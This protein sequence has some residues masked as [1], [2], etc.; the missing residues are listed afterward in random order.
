LANDA[1]SNFATAVLGVTSGPGL[2]LNPDGSFQYVPA[3]PGQFQFTYVAFDGVNSNS[4]T[5]SINVVAMPNP[6]VVTT[7]ADSGPGSLRAAMTYANATPGAQTITFAI[8]GV[9]PAAPA[10]INLQTGLPII[11]D[12]VTIDATT[13][14]GYD[15]RPVVELT[16]NGGGGVAVGFETGFDVNSVTIRGF[17]LTRFLSAGIRLLQA[18]TA[19]PGT[20]HVVTGN[21]LGTDRNSASLKGNSTGIIVRRDGA[22]VTGNVI[23]GNTGPGVL[24]HIDADGVQIVN[25]TIGLANDNVV[26]RPNAAGIRMLDSVDNTIIDG[27]IIAGNNG[28]GIDIQDSLAGDVTGTMIIAN[29]IGLNQLGDSVPNSL[30]GIQINNAPGTQIGIAGNGNVIS[31]HANATFLSG[32]PGIR[33]LGSPAVVPTIRANRIGTD[34]TGQ[35]ARPNRFE[36]IILYGRAEVGGLRSAN[37]GNLIS[38]NGNIGTGG[39][40]GILIGAGAEGSIVRGNTIGLTAGGA[41]LGNAYS[42]ITVSGDVTSI[43]IGGD[44]ND[45]INTISGNPAAGITVYSVDGDNPPGS[46]PRPREIQIQGNSIYGNGGLGIDLDNDGVSVN[47]TGDTDPLVG[48]AANDLQNYPALTSAVNNGATTQV[49]VDLSTLV[50]G[51]TYRVRFFAS[52]ACDTVGHGEGQT[53][54]GLA[55]IVQPG[56]SANLP[57]V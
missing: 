56:G 43:T 36:G 3:G 38:G 50:A 41:P 53:F 14:S 35:V 16:N 4:A 49:A 39:G 32:G 15:G 46:Q 31:G 23:S 2:T 55:D 47:D 29:R 10:V 11:S 7:A 54:L 18:E 37:E 34:P 12:A 57:L 27:N 19:P 1:V 42:G 52:P 8:G 40:T 26:A 51:Y 13:Q 5:V 30:G 44:G 45:L 9:T 22:L 20:G 33:V 21:I 28:L 6:L 17:A 48:N 25:N 24:I